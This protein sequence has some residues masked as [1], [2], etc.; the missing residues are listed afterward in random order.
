MPLG[1]ESPWRGMGVWSKAEFVEWNEMAKGVRRTLF[2]IDYKSI[3]ISALELY[4]LTIIY[5]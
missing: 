2:T 1:Q 4:A 5:Q 3:E